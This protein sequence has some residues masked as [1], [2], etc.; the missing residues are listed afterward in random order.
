MQ[1]MNHWQRV[2]AAIQGAPTDR[3]PV[4]FWRHFPEDDLH[5]ALLV[6]HTL[7]W[8]RQWEFDLVKFMPSGTYGVE[9]WGAV[10]SYRGLSNGAREVVQPAVMRTEDWQRIVPLDARRGSY[11]RQNEAL[12]AVAKELKGRVPLLTGGWPP[13]A[14]AAGEGIPGAVLPGRMKVGWIGLGR[15]GAPMAK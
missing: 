11:G 9:D 12:A 15:I 7:Q 4:A 10:S 6:T 5:P 14:L 13:A 3:T 2:E 8:Q 1:S